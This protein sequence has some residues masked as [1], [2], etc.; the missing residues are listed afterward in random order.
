MFILALLVVVA[1]PVGG[2]PGTKHVVWQEAACELHAIMQL[3]TLEVCANRIFPAALAAPTVPSIVVPSPKT[4]SSIT[5]RR[6]IAS[7]SN[8]RE[9]LS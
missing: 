4:P 2:V 1:A 8:C 5:E 7:P 3:V 6:M 9:L